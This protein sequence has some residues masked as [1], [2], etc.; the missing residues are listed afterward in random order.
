MTSFENL[1]NADPTEFNCIKVRAIQKIEWL[2]AKQHVKIERAWIQRVVIMEHDRNFCVNLKIGTRR[3]PKV[4]EAGGQRL[5]IF[6]KF[7]P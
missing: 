6:Q 5:Q 1:K 4:R 3:G 7:T 2:Q